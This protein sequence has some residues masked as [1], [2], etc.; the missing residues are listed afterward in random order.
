MDISVRGA[1][2]RSQLA[3]PQLQGG[4][5]D[6]S[7]QGTVSL[8]SCWQL[9]ASVTSLHPAKAPSSHLDCSRRE[10][11]PVTS[12]SQHC[13]VSL[14]T[15]W[16]PEADR[17]GKGGFSSFHS[18]NRKTGDY[19]TWKNSLNAAHTRARTPRHTSH[20][21]GTTAGMFRPSAVRDMRQRRAVKISRGS[22]VLVDSPRKN[23]L[24]SFGCS[25]AA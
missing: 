2:T 14:V 1:G 22:L 23:N 6:L 3:P 5:R 7:T 21:P 16:Q 25:T 4:S 19:T 24:F 13:A 10:R 11:K 15:A 17:G 8:E 9:R 12:L 20:T 18:R